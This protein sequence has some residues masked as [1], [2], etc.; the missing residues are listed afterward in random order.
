MDADYPEYG[1]LIPCRNTYKRLT[2]F[3]LLFSE[4]SLLTPIS[5]YFFGN[6]WSAEAEVDCNTI[7]QIG[8]KGD[9]YYDLLA[10]KDRTKLICEMKF[11]NGNDVRVLKDILKLAIPPQ[12]EAR[13][14]LLLV[15]LQPDFKSDLFSKL[16][17]SKKLEINPGADGLQLYYDDGVL[18]KGGKEVK[19]GIETTLRFDPNLREIDIEVIPPI[20]HEKERV[21]IFSISRR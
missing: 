13:Q 21:F 16:A 1:V 17:K 8:T 2:G 12:N 15:A 9:V 7:F 11:L 5:E 10:K 20:S 3:E 18:P 14:R 6:G 19:A 4:A